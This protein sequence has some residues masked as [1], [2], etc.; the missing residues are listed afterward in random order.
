[1]ALLR[2]DCDVKLLDGVCVS[3]IDRPAHR[4]LLCDWLLE[5][6]SILLA[7]DVAKS[8]DTSTHSRLWTATELAQHQTSVASFA[9]VTNSSFTWNTSGVGGRGGCNATAGALRRFTSAG[10][11]AVV[12]GLGHASAASLQDACFRYF[13]DKVCKI[14][15][16]PV[17]AAWMLEMRYWRT[18]ESRERE[19]L[20]VGVQNW[21]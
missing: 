13:I 3:L 10:Q 7:P 12:A 2:E 9:F 11:E 1:M 21:N 6:S 4:A 16:H 8:A 5:F 14:Q 19:G 18:G 20:R 17:V 15:V